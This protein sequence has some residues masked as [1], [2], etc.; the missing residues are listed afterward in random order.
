[1][2]HFT[3][4]K[5]LRK[6]TMLRLAGS[7]VVLAFLMGWQGGDVMRW[8]STQL[9]WTHA[10]SPMSSQSAVAILSSIASGMMAFSGVVFSL[11]VVG[12]QFASSAY[13][14]R[15]FEELGRNRL[16][17]HAVGI[18][19]GTFLY[20]LLAIRSVDLGGLTGIQT[21]IAVLSMLWL[22]ASITLWV[23][24]LPRFT[25]LSITRVLR[26]LGAAGLSAVNRGHGNILV[27]PIDIKANAESRGQVHRVT[28]RHHGSPSHW[29]GLHHK[30]L[31]DL[32]TRIDG[33]IHIPHRVG[34]VLQPGDVVAVVYAAR[35]ILNQE[36]FHRCL[37]FDEE[38]WVENDPA[39]ALVLL[40]DISNRALSPA[41]NDPNT[42]VDVLEQVAALLRAVAW[43]RFSSEHKHDDKHIPRVFYEGRK[44]EEWLQIGLFEIAQYGADSRPVRARLQKLRAELLQ[45]LPADYRDSVGGFF[46]SIDAGTDA[47]AAHTPA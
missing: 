29:V 30:R 41:I 25:S 10:F 1:M 45:S 39:Y 31:L 46:E 7:Y 23:A 32:L 43:S 4:R 2:A 9:Q 28:L 34:D 21:P 5:R 20:S 18:F 24:L 44:W 40:T 42:A 27:A 33:H 13:S 22:L 14:P 8:E 38:R 19:T 11:M 6:L 47:T 17:A 16:M 15:V 37:W 35:R 36:A 26:T 12:L 3:R